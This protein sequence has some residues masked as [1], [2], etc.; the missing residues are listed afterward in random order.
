MCCN[1][2]FNNVLVKHI[3]KT[4]YMNIHVKNVIKQG[5]FYVQ[6]N[7]QQNF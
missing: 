1:F 4:C 3:P 6:E 2:S 5:S 7:F